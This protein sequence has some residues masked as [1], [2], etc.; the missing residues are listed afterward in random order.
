M[1]CDLCGYFSF[2]EIRIP[3]PIN[4][5]PNKK[6]GVIFSPRKNQPSNVPTIGWAKNVRAADPASRTAN[7]LF[8]KTIARAVDMMPRN[9]RIA[10][11]VNGGMISSTTLLTT[12][13]PPQI[14]AAPNPLSNPYKVLFIR[15]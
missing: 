12:Y 7:A 2:A 15:G 8:Y 4:T 5:P 11:N 6:S 9:K 10:T 14:E 1:L 3:I 13:L